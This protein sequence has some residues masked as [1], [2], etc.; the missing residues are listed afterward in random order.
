ML[1][2]ES[3]DIDEII[4]HN[5]GT[6][7]AEIITQLG[8][9]EFRR[10]ERLETQRVLEGPPSVV[11]PGGGW[12]AEGNNLHTLRGRAFSIYL[13]TTPE[14]AASRVGGTGDRPLLAGPE[15]LSRMRDLL[16]TRRP[17]YEECDATISTDGKTIHE[18]ADEVVELARRA[19]VR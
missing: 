8:E 14:T 5:E 3:C 1:G 9:R 6:S 7:V 15:P 13:E 2:V 19:T 17:L 11:I 4:E 16:T 18:V 10:L 12:A